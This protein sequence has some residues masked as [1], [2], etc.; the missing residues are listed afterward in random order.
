MCDIPVPCADRQHKQQPSNV[1]EDEWKDQ[2][3]ETWD[4][5]VDLKTL[6]VRGNCRTAD[7][8]RATTF[9]RRSQFHS[10]QLLQHP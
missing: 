5:L 7:M 9:S 2:V 6:E 10:H 3:G 1:F 8:Y 4:D